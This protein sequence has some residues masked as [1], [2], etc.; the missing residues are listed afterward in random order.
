MARKAVGTKQRFEIFKRDEFTCQYCGAH[1]PAA[2]LHVD[3]IVAVANGG[4]N[5]DDNLLTSCSQCNLGKGAR[6]LTDVPQSL[7][8]KAAETREREAQIAGYN[9]VMAA[10][11]ARVEDDTWS[12]LHRYM[13]HFKRDRIS[14]A[15]FQSVK[16]FVELL[17]AHDCMDAMDMA[18]GRK[19]RSEYAT[20]KY[21][22]GICWRWV[23]EGRQCGRAT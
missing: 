22:C 13:E 10:K 9:A 7:A 8:S 5:D 15:D 18:I 12:T 3:H 21:F 11:R 1:P 20:F 2:I 14:E 23:R 16:R 4:T 6:R 17:G 19:G